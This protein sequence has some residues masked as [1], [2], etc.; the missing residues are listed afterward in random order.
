[1]RVIAISSGKGG[2]GKSIITVSLSHVFAEL[3]Y[4]VLAIDGNIGNGNL[5][6]L[7]RD[8]GNYSIIDVITGKEPIG[9]V[10]RKPA[11][12]IAFLPAGAG[13]NVHTH[14][15]SHQ[16][17][18]LF[19]EL[20]LIDDIADVVL[21]DCPSGLTELNTFLTTASTDTVIVTTP[22]VTSI[23]SSLSLISILTGRYGEKDIKIAVN[24]TEDESEALNTFEVIYEQA[25]RVNG[26]R[27]SF[28]GHIPFDYTVMESIRF[29]QPVA[30]GEKKSNLKGYFLNLSQ[31]ILRN[32]PEEKIKKNQQFF[33][34]RLLKEE[35]DDVLLQLNEVGK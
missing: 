35:H 25:S 2:V 23:I 29:L 7:F 9:K 3:G 28:V 4:R 19:T 21:I 11:P 26:T 32:E 27:V 31:E 16:K 5:D 17:M 22:E 34:K 14:L 15:T 13:M 20:D 6:L 33:T 30:E 12:G 18:T 1:L 24:M 10:L 8:M